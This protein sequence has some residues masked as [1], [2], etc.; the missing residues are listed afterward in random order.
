MSAN[1]NFD[2]LAQIV[3]DRFGIDQAKLID[4]L[5]IIRAHYN[6]AGIIVV[7]QHLSDLI[8]TF[9]KLRAGTSFEDLDDRLSTL[10]KIARLNDAPGHFIE[11]TINKNN[12]NETP[13]RPLTGESSLCDLFLIQH[14]SQEPKQNNLFE[15]ILAWFTWQTFHFQKKILSPEKYSDY[16]LGKGD[17]NLKNMDGSR[18]YGAFL[19][20]RQLGD[21]N[22]PENFETLK[23]V[24]HILNEIDEESSIK[25]AAELRI[26]KKNAANIEEYQIRYK[27]GLFLFQVWFKEKIKTKSSSKKLISKV[28]RNQKQLGLRRYGQ[29]FSVLQRID[30]D[31][32]HSGL[33]VEISRQGTEDNK[34]E[35]LLTGKNDLNDDPTELSVEPEILLFL[36]TTKGNDLL[37][38][39]Y[40]S[41]SA[42]HHIESGNA[43]LLWPKWRLS[44]TAISQVLS[45]IKFID[46]DPPMR[47]RAKLAIGLSLLTGRSL[48]EV[49][50]PVFVENYDIPELAK[51]IGINTSSMVLIVPAGTP[52][53]KNVTPLPKFCSSWESS[54]RL[55][56]PDFM[57]ALVKKVSEYNSIPRQ[58]TIT[59]IATELLDQLPEHYEVTPK[60]IQNALKLTLQEK[61]KGDL[62]VIKAITNASGLNYDNLIHYASFNRKRLEELWQ[63]CIETWKIQIPILTLPSTPCERVGSPFGI[64]INKVAEAIQEIK[65][66]YTA[67][68]QEK[69][70]DDAL[71]LLTLYTVLWLNLATAGRRARNPFPEFISQDGWALIRDKHRKDESTDRYLP[72]SIGVRKQIDVL[73][74]RMKALGINQH[75]F[76]D[77]I[78][79]SSYLLHPKILSKES[80]KNKITNFTP[81]FMGQLEFVSDLPGNWGRKLVR[82][83][84]SS[85]S[86]R[87][88]DAGLGHWVRGRHPWT[89]TCSFPSSLF[90]QEWLAMQNRLEKELGF[91]LLDMTELNGL[92]SPQYLLPKKGNKKDS[93]A[94][95]SFPPEWIIDKLSNKKFLEYKK[96]TL[97]SKAPNGDVA[98]ELGQLLLGDLAKDDSIDLPAAAESYCALMRQEKGIPIY[99]QAPR[100][101]FQKNWMVSQYAF[102]SWCYIEQQLLERIKKDLSKLPTVD[103]EPNIEISIGRLLVAASLYG[104]IHRSSHLGSLMTFLSTE[105][106]IQA[107]GDAR[108][109]ELLVPCDRSKV[110]IRR[111]LLLRPYLSSLF[112]IERERVKPILANITQTKKSSRYKNDQWN[113]CFK[114]YLAF[115]GLPNQLSISQWLKALQQNLLLTASPL[116]AAYSA[117]EVLSE[118]LPISE[119]QRLSEYDV[120]KRSELSHLEENIENGLMVDDTILPK[121]IQQI[122]TLRSKPESN[123]TEWETLFFINKND[124][125]INNAEN[126]L[127]FFGKHMLD[128]FCAG[129]VSENPLS[130]ST[131]MQRFFEERLTIVATG[132]IGFSDISAEGFKFDERSLQHLSEL[133]EGYF[134]AKKHHGAWN[135]FRKFL[136][137]FNNFTTGRILEANESRVSAKVFSS[138]EIFQIIEKLD[139][140]GSGLKPIV[141]KIAQWHF[142]L[143]AGTGARRAESENIRNLDVDDNMLRIRPYDGHTLKTAG[144]ARVL[145]IGILEISIQNHLHKIEG[146]VN[147]KVMDGVDD[148][149]TS[150]D[151]FFNKVSQLITA[152]TGDADLGMHHLRHTLASAY[153]LKSLG[154][155]VDLSLLNNDLPWVNEWLPSNQ[156]LSVLLGPE[157]QCGQGIKVTSAM[158]GHIHETTTLKHYIHTLFAALYAHYLAQEQPDLHIAFGV[159][160]KSRSNLYLHQAINKEVC[161]SDEVVREMRNHIEVRLQKIE[162]KLQK[163]A[164]NTTII[165]HSQKTG[166]NHQQTELNKD[167]YCVSASAEDRLAQLEIIEKYFLNEEGKAPSD[168]EQWIEALQ[169]LTTI[170]SG[171][172]GC[173][174]PRHP[175]PQVGKNRDLPTLLDA[176]T[177]YKHAK[178]LLTWLQKLE[179][180]N[181][182]DY[183]WLINKWLYHSEAEKGLIR[184]EPNEEKYVEDLFDQASTFGNIRLQIS[185]IKNGYRF[186]IRIADSN[187][188]TIREAGAVRWVMSWV[189]IDML[190]DSDSN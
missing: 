175:L 63:S 153:A 74:S 46:N 179:E 182:K 148:H 168:I 17:K 117:G 145:P 4:A 141:R 70:E 159:R 8:D 38:G 81:S 165:I 33:I 125:K 13:L 62:A 164:T 84:Q 71:T 133:T 39:F 111:T 110:P 163:N 2:A 50:A 155:T 45:S 23:Q 184:L 173:N 99:A 3:Q 129:N 189:S 61:S 51:K 116:L 100:K 94:I 144:S 87:F 112:I 183:R 156:Q 31:N 147:K 5:F 89:H 123:I 88:K 128:E 103:T 120:S 29:A 174:N 24:K 34:S 131:R 36:S 171:K 134:S 91:E 35:E 118:D 66:L 22:N 160:M 6:L 122:R 138:L 108:A 10:I 57:H 137:E 16:L 151:N 113:K 139:S 109:I 40:A 7:C 82:S 146:D 14:G 142:R 76:F 96:A 101:Q 47:H 68:I 12:R 43:G 143:T 135:S 181:P 115:L 15:W 59:N 180:K 169:K 78:E 106:P 42:L 167:E 67:A 162:K 90:K 85:L 92:P 105:L 11:E 75:V 130:I 161:P 37:R 49:S 178:E 69:N 104:G 86:G 107:I 132:L 26:S 186:Q 53:L 95:E 136:K 102:S 177:A 98:L 80:K 79:H 1:K 58:E 176:G 157:G 55:P 150:G 93:N 56:L 73:R 48:S 127:K 152:V 97:G 60:S 158:L 83:E 21:N 154:N 25:A 19:A 187:G 188:N 41:K 30:A 114:E 72:L 190:K 64:E 18:I 20:L 126:I 124:H 185:K 121:I 28:K 32:I 27:L 52:Q 119:L 44:N 166:I 140:R 77:A 54:I 65:T 149:S 172:K 9:P 170:K